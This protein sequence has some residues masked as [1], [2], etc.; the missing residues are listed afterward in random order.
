MVLHVWVVE[1]P[2]LVIWQGVPGNDY[3]IGDGVTSGYRQ[4][5][6]SDGLA[7]GMT[8]QSYQ[9]L[10]GWN[11]GATSYTSVAGVVY[12]ANSVAFYS[13]D[14]LPAVQCK[15]PLGQYTFHA[16]AA[17]IGGTSTPASFSSNHSPKEYG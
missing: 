1:G 4:D 9:S 7:N 5:I 8:G 13:T 11:F 2:N 17:P 14:L 3:E 6:F 16:T 10:I 12:P 15:L